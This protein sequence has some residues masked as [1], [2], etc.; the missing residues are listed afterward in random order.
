MGLSHGDHG[1]MA[2]ILDAAPHPVAAGPRSVRGL[3]GSH[4]Q[5]VVAERPGG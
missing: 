3:R 4:Q 2:Q 1:D 5:K